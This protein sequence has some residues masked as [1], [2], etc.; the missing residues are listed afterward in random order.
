M[1]PR[2]ISQSHAII[3]GTGRA[4]TTF[5]VHLLTALGVDTGF[6]LEEIPREIYSDANAGLEWDP[7]DPRAPYLIKNPLFFALAQEMLENSKI[8]ID[9][10]FIPI[11]NIDDVALSRI[12]VSTLAKN[13][14][15]A[16]PLTAPGGMVEVDSED[17]QTN[18]LSAQLIELLLTLSKHDVPITL[19]HFPT[20]VTDPEYLYK[21]L[22]PLIS[23]VPFS[24]F[25]A[26][27]EAIAKPDLV[28]TFEEGTKQES[29]QET[30]A[31]LQITNFDLRESIGILTNSA[32]W[33]ITRP[34]REAKHLLKKISAR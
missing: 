4:G 22:A 28:S 6:T 13:N 2:P 14:M 19:I 21:K 27:F 7:R 33:K 11:R 15:G 31:K 16:V 18:I 1:D 30:V 29:I 24:E 9:H 12:A 17:S 10:V 26:H 3:A 20:L 32:S 8:Y 25:L 23:R 5:L 34:L